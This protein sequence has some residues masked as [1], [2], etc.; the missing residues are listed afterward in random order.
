MNRQFSIFQLLA[1]P[2]RTSRVALAV[3]L[4]LGSAVMAVAADPSFRTDAG[5]S[6]L[7][8]YSL[9]PGEF[10]PPGS[11]HGVS[12]E[13]IALDHVNRTGVLRPDRD[14]TQRRGDWDISRPF[15]LLPFGSLRY[16]DA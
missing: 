12:G 9:R 3:V 4:I 16:H 5:A 14:D 1:M 13:L 15:V 11:A 8:W 6:S 10:P 7:P 2:R